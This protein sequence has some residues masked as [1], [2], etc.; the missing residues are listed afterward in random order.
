MAV[1]V[2]TVSVD[3]VPGTDLTEAIRRIAREEIVK[4]A[5]EA[6]RQCASDSPMEGVLYALMEAASPRD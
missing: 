6:Y 1:S 3:I 4:A 2:G 5:Y